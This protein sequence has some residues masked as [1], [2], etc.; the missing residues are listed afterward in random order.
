MCEWASHVQRVPHCSIC[1]GP[2]TGTRGPRTVTSPAHP[3]DKQETVF[4]LFFKCGHI[5]FL[6]KNKSPMREVGVVE[7]RGGRIRNVY[8]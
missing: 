5:M 4:I 1:A 3:E 6:C 7:G 2:T 8:L